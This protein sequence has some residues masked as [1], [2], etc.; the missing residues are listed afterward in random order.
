[1]S[2]LFDVGS[3]VA[4]P[5]QNITGDDNS[6]HNAIFIP[7]GIGDGFDSAHVDDLEEWINEMTEDLPE[8]TSFIL[9][10]VRYI[11]T[12]ERDCIKSFFLVLFIF[13]D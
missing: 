12:N 11:V 10:T 9:P 8:L 5:S 4:K 2:R 6:D 13:R 3:H 1:M 7:N